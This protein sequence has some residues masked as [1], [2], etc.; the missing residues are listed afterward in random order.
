MHIISGLPG[1]VKIVDDPA[2]FGLPEIDAISDVGCCGDYK[3]PFPAGDFS[4]D[5]RVDYEDL[6][7]LQRYWLFE[8]TDSNEPANSVDIYDD[9]FV[10]F[11]DYS[12]MADNWQ[13]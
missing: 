2:A 11:F 12:I 1:Y 9:D 7:L 10:D 6:A 3:H 13:E 4:K 8:I 5:C